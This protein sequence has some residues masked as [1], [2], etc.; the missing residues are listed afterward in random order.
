MGGMGGGARQPSR[1]GLTIEHIL[2][3][4]SGEL[5]KSR[6]TTVELGA[7]AGAMGEIENMMG[8][9]QPSSL[10]PYPQQL[11]PVRS[12]QQQQQLGQ[13]NQQGQN[14]PHKADHEPSLALQALQS[15]L[16]DTQTLLHNHVE[17][18]RTLEV[19]LSEQD[20]IKRDVNALRDL[21][22]EQRD[23]H[24]LSSQHDDDDDDSRS[25]H[26]VVPHELESVPEEDETEAEESDEERSARREELG[27]PR[28]PEPSSFGMHDDDD[29]HERGMGP[30]QPPGIPDELTRR[31]NVLAD[32][33]ESALEM[34]RNLQAQHATAQQTIESL[35]NK[36]MALENKVKE[37]QALQATEE[38]RRE[39][40]LS[41]REKEQ[42]E[43]MV[44]MF[45]DFKKTI[46]ERW[47]VVKSDWQAEHERAGKRHEEW[48]GR[49]KTLEDGVSKA[50]IKI[51]TGI[52]SLTSQ[53]ALM[54]NNGN[55]MPGNR[56]NGLVTPPSPRSLSG[57]DSDSDQPMKTVLKPRKR[58]RSRN[59]RGRQNKASRSR[60]PATSTSATLVDGMSS[61]NGT[62]SSVASVASLHSRRSSQDSPSESQKVT[63][64]LDL[65]MSRLERYPPTPEDSIHLE[66]SKHSSEIQVPQPMHVR[67]HFFSPTYSY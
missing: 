61:T 38:Q 14:Q 13:Q 25:V 4:L 35:E 23:R 7:V 39:E 6:E 62:E 45:A 20:D 48:E 50:S 52:A 46:E 43:S 65:D 49:V 32:Q 17:K 67:D 44:S 56:R 60:S 16:V 33:L 1:N 8:G 27:R 18:V 40:R 58:S 30:S 37:S 12:Q 51:D 55:T 54:K 36:V 10:P 53:L 21:I 66:G 15:Q 24:R 57:A 9:G 28:T 42:Q 2:Q 31:L 64:R 34:S 59:H 11:P 63:P 29:H 41:S 3:R 19:L 22:E 47:E 5:Q 26:T